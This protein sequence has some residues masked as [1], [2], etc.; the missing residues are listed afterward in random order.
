MELRTLGGVEYELAIG[1]AMLAFVFLLGL[2]E[3]MFLIVSV[4]VHLI[5]MWAGQKE[6]QFRKVYIKY[7]TQGVRYDPWPKVQP[8]K[9]KRDVEFQGDKLC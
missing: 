4:L 9:N 2:G 7:A 8:H 6:Q 1:N 3:P 5:L